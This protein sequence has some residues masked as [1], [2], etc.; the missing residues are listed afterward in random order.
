[1]EELGICEYGVAYY[2]TGAGIEKKESLVPLRLVST[3]LRHEL[4]R[5]LAVIVQ[6]VNKLDRHISKERI[7]PS[8]PLDRILGSTVII[9]HFVQM[10]TGVNELH[11]VTGGTPE[12]ALH[13]ENILEKYFSIHSIV[14]NER[15]AKDLTSDFGGTA[16]V[17]VLANRDVLE[18]VIS[19]LIDNVWK[20]AT[21]GTAVRVRVILS[22]T[23][24]ADIVFQNSSKPIP[25]GLD[26]FSQGT[27]ADL[28]SDGFGYGLYWARI[29]FDYY[30]FN[31]DLQDGGLELDHVQS[32][33]ERGLAMQTFTIRNIS[34]A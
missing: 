8:R 20:Y 10:L 32:V 15:R 16:K 22:G 26:I 5:Y 3:N 12:E 19:V 2:R 18:Y 28:E 33:H 9:D 4:H 6:E 27:Q 14:R 1:M 17:M 11:A 13:L 25:P 31:R 30:N 21:S 23:G 34:L 24:S 7:D 29:L